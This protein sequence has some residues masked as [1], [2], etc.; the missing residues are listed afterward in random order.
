[1]AHR[2]I[3]K[4]ALRNGLC[5]RPVAHHGFSRGVCVDSRDRGGFALACLLQRRGRTAPGALRLVQLLDWHI[6]FGGKRTQPLHR[7]RGKARIG[8]LPMRGA[9][10]TRRELRWAVK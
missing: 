1:M 8:Y 5:S 7:A 6:A 4:R 3:V 10:A 9:S 2:R